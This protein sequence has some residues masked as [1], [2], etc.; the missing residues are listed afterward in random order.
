MTPDAVDA[1]TLRLAGHARETPLLSSPALDALAGRRVL[2]K[3]ECLQHTGSFKYRGAKAAVT[4]LDAQGIGGGV[5][6]YSSG[7]HAQGIAKA[8]AESGRI[9]VILMPADAPRVKIENTQRLGA[10]VIT[11]DRFGEDRDAIGQALADERGLILI[12]PY[13]EP[14]VIAGQGSVGVELA[15]QAAAA[16]VDEADVLIC[17]GGGGLAAGISLALSRHA[18]G[19]HPRTVEPDGFDDVAR[20]LASG[21]RTGND[22]N[23]RSLCDAILTPMPGKLTFPILQTHGRPGLAVSDDDVLKAIALAYRHLDLRVEPGGAVALAA[24]LFHPEL[25]PDSPVIAIISG[26]NVS[27]DVFAMALAKAG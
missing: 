7:N 8:A 5:F 10:E 23:A 20:S 25:P 27:D 12:R 22:P 2:I 11:Y 21:E 3:A 18:P 9:A 13:D 19:L 15:R 24:A 1:A 6:A 26:G 17:C 16:G 14:E 4:A